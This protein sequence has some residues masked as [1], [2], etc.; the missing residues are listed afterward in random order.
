MKHFAVTLFLALAF[1][2]N[3]SAQYTQKLQENK[4]G[5]G[6]VT[7]SQ[8]KEIDDLVNGKTKTPA[9]AP[10]TAAKPP[11]DNKPRQDK[12]TEEKPK[13][14]ADDLRD[15]Q[16]QA[17]KEKEDSA[18]AAQARA[19]KLRREAAEREKEAAAN[20][21]QGKKVMKGAKTVTGYRVQVYS[22]GNTREDRIK[23]EQIGN[24]MKAAFPDQPIYTHFYSPRWICRMGNFKTYDEA[25]KICKKVRAMGYKSAS[26]VKGKINVR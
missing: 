11:Q 17:E 22:G 9:P 20:E 1:T 23:A 3:A 24:K 12:K 15:Q 13:Q 19:E 7:I 10:T 26:V 6:T 8:S 2:A 4:Q 18:K 25:M 5:E 16:A 21:P 14:Q